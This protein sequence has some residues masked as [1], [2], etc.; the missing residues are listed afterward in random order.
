VIGSGVLGVVAAL[1]I[2]LGLLALALQLIKRLQNPSGWGGRGVPLQV[3]K[4]IA[5]GPRQGVALLRVADRVLVVSIAE[6]GTRLLTELKDQALGEALAPAPPEREPRAFR[7]PQWSRLALIAALLLAP[8]GVRAQASQAPPVPAASARAAGPDLRGFG[9]TAPAPPRVEIKLGE[10][11]GALHL[12]GAV[13]LVV[14][15]GFLTL[16]P[17]LF[18][19]MTSFTRILIVLHFLRSALGTQTTPPGQLLVAVAVLLTGVVMNPVLQKTNRTAIQPYVSGQISQVEAYSLGVKPFREFMLANTRNQDLAMFTELSG[20][21][22]ARSMD[23]VPTVTV[24][25]A[26]VTSELRT[27]FQMGF[28]IFLPFVVVDVIVASVLMSLG[29][30]MLPPVMISLPFKLLL[31]VLADGWTLVIQNLVASF[32]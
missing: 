27:A 26:F 23:E 12:S 2:T 19:L 15:L 9:P 20:V 11:S 13:G 25:S 32:R 29:M 22:E 1:A 7:L 14:F 18:L 6:N 10:G 24:V 21:S 3:L 5:V 31:F 16:L 28:V 4:R 30:F 17:A 8:A